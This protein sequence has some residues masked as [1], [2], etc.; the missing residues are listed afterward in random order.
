MAFAVKKHEVSERRACELLGMDRSS[1]RYREKPEREPEVRQAVERLAQSRPRFGYRR[2]TVLLRKEGRTV[3]PKRV[4][5]LC[6]ELGVTVR[7]KRRKRLSRARP[8]AELLTALNQEWAMDFV[9]DATAS[10]QV[11][12][13][14]TVEDAYSRE[15]VEIEV[16]TS[17]SSARVSRVL[18]RAAAERGWPAR[19]RTDNGPEFTSREFE[20]WCKDKRVRLIHIEPGKPVQNAVIESFN[21]RFR[22]ECLNVNWFLNLGD[23]RAKVAAWKWDYNWV[24]PHGALDGEAPAKFAALA[25]A[26]AQA[27]PSGS[28]FASA[29]ASANTPAIFTGESHL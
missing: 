11:I 19:I 26:S 23:A 6:R 20:S 17:I 27:R 16:G 13:A 9:S 21:G 25:R 24:R 4:W 28:P 12:R 10:G 29:P 22:D 3:N 5:R 1:C 8:A 18:E 15:C 2:L 14:L 7:R